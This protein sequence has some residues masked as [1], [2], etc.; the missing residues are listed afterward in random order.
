[1][2][3]ISPVWQRETPKAD[4]PCHP[5]QGQNEVFEHM[6]VR[7][8]CGVMSPSPTALATARLRPNC[9]S[10]AGARKDGG[11]NVPEC[12]KIICGL[13]PPKPPSPSECKRLNDE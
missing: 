5:Y 9:R 7:P 3:Q 11:N 4:R 13:S 6:A 1:M 10:G 12:S 8:A 2:R